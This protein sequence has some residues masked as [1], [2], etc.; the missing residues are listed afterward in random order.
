[1]CPEPTLLQET[2]MCSFEDV[3]EALDC[4]SATSLHDKDG[5]LRTQCRGY[6]ECA[7]GE[8]CLPAPV[9]GV[10]RDC[11]TSGCE[12]CDEA[13][14]S[15]QCVCYEDCSQRAVCV[16]FDE[17]PFENDCPTK[18]S[19]SCN[20]VREAQVGVESYLAGANAPP[21][22]SDAPFGLEAR[23]ALESC[24][25]DLLAAEPFAC[26]YCESWYDDDL[27][28]HR[29]ETPAEVLARWT[30]S[31]ANATIG[32][33]RGCGLTVLFRATNLGTDHNVYDDADT[34]IGFSEIYLT[35]SQDSDCDDDQ[36]SLRG[37]T[38]IA[39]HQNI[40]DWCPLAPRQLFS[41]EKQVNCLA[42]ETCEVCG[43]GDWPT[44]ET[45]P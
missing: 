30:Q 18:N 9:A 25:D 13:T 6:D 29:Q 43:D 2:A 39:C 45:V 37:G 20:E 23:A 22:V 1:M 24:R 3:C 40:A 12:S 28:I 5:C 33:A 4:G 36:S 21:G 35:R 8:R 19:R 14:G 27:L 26:D 34:L 17:F 42:F 44:C 16:S 11:W 32:I 41:L 7:E 31:C 38:Q 15:C 10:I